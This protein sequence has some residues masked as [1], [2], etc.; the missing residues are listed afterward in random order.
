MS[1]S[2]GALRRSDR[3]MR[4]TISRIVRARSCQTKSHEYP[5]VERDKGFLLVRADGVAQQLAASTTTSLLSVPRICI[6][7]A[8]NLSSGMAA[9]ASLLSNRAVRVQGGTIPTTRTPLS[10]NMKRCD[11]AKEYGEIDF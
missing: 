9:S 11:I 6:A 8:M 7:S 5:I 10:R 1:P 3:L 4:A 2:D